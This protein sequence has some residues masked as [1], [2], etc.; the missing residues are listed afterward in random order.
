M[1]VSPTLTRD[2]SAHL[3]LGLRGW[4]GMITQETKIIL[5]GCEK[6]LGL[7]LGTIT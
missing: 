6:H 3:T 1:I 4:G 5:S 2:E 7:E